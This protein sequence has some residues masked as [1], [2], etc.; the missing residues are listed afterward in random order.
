LNVLGVLVV[1]D[2]LL[3]FYGVSALIARAI[4]STTSSTVMSEVST[5]M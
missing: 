5:K 3:F 1:L 2:V 4:S